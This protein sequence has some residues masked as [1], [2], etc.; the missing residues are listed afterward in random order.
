MQ[1][2][3]PSCRGIPG[4]AHPVGSGGLVGILLVLVAVSSALAWNKAGH[5]VAAAIAYADLKQNNPE[6]LARVVA[7]LQTHPQFGTTWA[8]RLAQLHLSPEEQDLSLF[9][10]AARWPDDT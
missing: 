10:L 9:M 8:P 6:T 2:K 1:L 3:R 7:L 5:M 4:K